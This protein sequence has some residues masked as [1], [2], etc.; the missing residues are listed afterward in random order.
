MSRTKKEILIALKEIDEMQRNGQFLLGALYL[1][2]EDIKAI[3]DLLEEDPQKISQYGRFMGD[4][5]VSSGP[6]CPVTVFGKKGNSPRASMFIS[7]NP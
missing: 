3:E 4:P 7:P 1:E 5:V 2:K 6:C